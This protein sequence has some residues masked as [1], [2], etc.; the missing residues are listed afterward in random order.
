MRVDEV[1][2]QRYIFLV[3]ETAREM[4]EALGQCRPDNVY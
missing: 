4:S 1:K 3:K 2:K